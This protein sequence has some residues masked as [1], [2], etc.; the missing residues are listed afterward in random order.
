MTSTINT[1]VKAEPTNHRL[2]VLYELITVWS[3][4][5]WMSGIFTFT[6][7]FLTTFAW[8]NLSL[9]HFLPLISIFLHHEKR[10]MLD[11]FFLVI[12]GNAQSY[13]RKWHVSYHRPLKLRVLL[14]IKLTNSMWISNLTSLFEFTFVDMHAWKKYPRKHKSGKLT[15]ARLVGSCLKFYFCTNNIIPKESWKVLAQWAVSLMNS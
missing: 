6:F 15:C 14:S 11:L 3:G 7:L 4:G 10:L 12:F 2:R 8:Q 13:R 1:C 9:T 5:P